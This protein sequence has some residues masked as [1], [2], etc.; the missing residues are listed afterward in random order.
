MCSMNEMNWI[1][2]TTFKIVA[3]ELSFTRAAQRLLVSV[4]AVSQRVRRLE[5]CLGQRLL[6]R[7]TTHV[8][9]TEAGALALR[10]ISSIETQWTQTR[11]QISG[12][13]EPL[14]ELVRPLC[15]ALYR[16][17]PCDLPDRMATIAAPGASEVRHY[18]SVALGLDQ[19]RRGEVDF[20]WWRTWHR[21]HTGFGEDLRELRSHEVVAED[22]WAYLN[23]RHPM[24]GGP[25]LSLGQLSGFALVAPPEESAVAVPRQLREASGHEQEF[26]HYPESQELAHELLRTS[27][28]VTLGGPSEPLPSGL[29]RLPLSSAVQIRYMLSWR[30]HPAVERLAPAVLDLYRRW[31]M[32]RTVECN[33]HHHRRMLSDPETYPGLPVTEYYPSEPRAMAHAALG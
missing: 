31:Y 23:C 4:S 33:P 21:P 32:E 6:A 15:T 16:L 20:L 17:T 30:G 26:V 29:H 11:A 24:A 13:E 18:R 7:T 14:P 10:S 19:L 28:A 5:R 12:L 9:L 1:D 3:E 27:T 22:A 8:Q 25:G 2:L